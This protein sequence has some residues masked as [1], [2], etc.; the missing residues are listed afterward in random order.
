MDRDEAL[1]QA[2]SNGHL[3]GE[4]GRREA[5]DGWGAAEFARCVRCHRAQLV[6]YRDNYNHR[7]STALRSPCAP[8]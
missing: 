1:R 3:M 7:E 2:R 8:P 5:A 6:G 4:W